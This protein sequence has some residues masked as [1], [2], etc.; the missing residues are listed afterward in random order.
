MVIS[1]DFFSNNR[2]AFAEKLLDNTA[3]FFFSGDEKKM[4]ADT[5]YRFLPDRNFYYLSG[6]DKEDMALLIYKM[7]G[8]VKEILFI[9]PYDETLARWVGGRMSAEDAA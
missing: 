6:L 1:A 8:I 9:L 7:D 4:C 2:K 5:E 3:A